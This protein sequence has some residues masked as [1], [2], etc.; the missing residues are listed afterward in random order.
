[1]VDPPVSL[2]CFSPLARCL[3]VALVLVPMAATPPS[4]QT[5]SVPDSVLWEGRFA[6]F[7]AQQVTLFTLNL[8]G[9]VD[10]KFH[11]DETIEENGLPPTGDLGIPDDEATLRVSDLVYIDNLYKDAVD[12]NTSDGVV[13][14]SFRQDRIRL[15]FDQGVPLWGALVASVGLFL[16]GGVGVGIVL[17]RRERRRIAAETAE[18]QRSF[19]AREA[20]RSRLARELH[21]GPLQDVHALRMLSGTSDPESMDREASRIAR[22]LRAIAEGLRPPALGRF[23]LSAALSAHTNRVKDRYPDVAIRLQLDEDGVGDD[24]L[25]DIVRSSL[26]RIVQES[27]TNA[28]EHGGAERLQVTCRLP[29]LSTNGEIKV[30]VVDDGLGFDWADGTPDLAELADGGHFGLVG[31]HERAAAIGGRLDLIP[32][33]LDGQG[34]T[35]RVSV[36]DMRAPGASSTVK[37]RRLTT[38]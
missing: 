4:A 27:I 23:G 30:E 35:V 15:M 28:I 2:L 29:P 19:H 11:K 10:L 13:A 1:M 37:R 38:A 12:E 5:P 9:T 14:F 17:T 16:I 24:A 36:P 34:A 18:R 31:M 22:E 7:D 21:D 26:F 32:V 33:G 25:P 6:D 3:A 20:E 8:D